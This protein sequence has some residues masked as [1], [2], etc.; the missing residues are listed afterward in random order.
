MDEFKEQREKIK[1]ASFKDKVKYYTYY[2]KWHAFVV[3]AVIALVA[4]WIHD[5]K[6]HKENALFAALLNNVTLDSE[7]TL[8][9][10]Y[11]DYAGID[12][13]KYQIILDNT[14]NID[15]T[16]T[17]EM[18]V[19]SSQRMMVYTAAAELDTIIGGEDIFPDY[20]YNG[21]FHDLRDILSEEQIKAYEPYFYYV[22]RTV[23]ET[24]LEAQT[25]MESTVI[26]EIPDPTKP[27]EMEDPV[28]VGIFVTNC[29]KLR[30]DYL[31][32]GESAIG[33]LTNAP[34]PE[35]SLKFIDFLFE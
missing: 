26:S 17:D 24:I 21:I 25:N 2:Y 27:E 33:V 9:K 31:F 34:H 8:Y 12:L 5:V 23:V 32:K 15:P 10:D 1:N 30:D 13:E 18:S 14:L 29:Q 20:A 4:I 16:A 28:P 11:A 22:D 35:N 6:T 7:S 3:I 19:S